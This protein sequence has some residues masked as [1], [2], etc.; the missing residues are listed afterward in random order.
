[1]RERHEIPLYWSVHWICCAVSRSAKA[2]PHM[3]LAVHGFTLHGV[4]VQVFSACIDRDALFISVQWL[5]D[6]MA[7]IT[8]SNMLHWPHSR[9]R[10]NS[11]FNGRQIV[12]C[13]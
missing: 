10:T 7:G 12:G 2:V 13:R 4:H 5:L 9:P 3:M 11:R 1:M 8:K 6:K